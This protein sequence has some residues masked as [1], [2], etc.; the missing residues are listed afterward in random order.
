MEGKEGKAVSWKVR[1]CLGRQWDA[2]QKGSAPA[3]SGSAIEKQCPGRQWKPNRKAV[4]D[5]GGE[6]VSLGRPE[7]DHHLPA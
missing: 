1:Q 4:P 7:V 2:Q 6:Y 3:G 5:H